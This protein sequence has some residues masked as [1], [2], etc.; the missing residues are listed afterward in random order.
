MKR[1]FWETRKFCLSF[2]QNFTDLSTR[3]HSKT[4]QVQTLQ[5]MLRDVESD[6]VFQSIVR[7]SRKTS[8]D[9]LYGRRE[10]RVS[11]AGGRRISRIQLPV[12]LFQLKCSFVL[13]NIFLQSQQ[14]KASIFTL[15]VPE[16]GSQGVTGRNRRSSSVLLRR[17]LATSEH[18]PFSVWPQTR[19]ASET[20]FTITPVVDI[21]GGRSRRVSDR[22]RSRL[23]STE[24]TEMGI[25][26]PPYYEQNVSPD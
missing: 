22:P 16:E 14:R 21:S 4:A 7:G 20:R 1:K 12:I 17:S 18:Q 5:D 26:R 9:M 24:E 8:V 15:P 2:F 25:V 19:P 10:S 23:I 3:P 6:E 11:M 13:P